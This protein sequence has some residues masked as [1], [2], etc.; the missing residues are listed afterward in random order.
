MGVVEEEEEEEEEVVEVVEEIEEEEV[1]E[2]EEEDNDDNDDNS[3]EEEEMDDSNDYVKEKDMEY[4]EEEDEEEDIQTD[5]RKAKYTYTFNGHTVPV[6]GDKDNIISLKH[7]ISRKLNVL[8]KQCHYEGSVDAS[9]RNVVH[10]VAQLAT[11]LDSTFRDYAEMC[12]LAPSFF[13]CHRKRA[14][15]RLI[16]LDRIVDEYQWEG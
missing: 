3:E 8:L 14:T 6:S 13:K 2:E 15:Q 16:D 11:E 5:A 7:I 1:E 12:R 10:L 9:M 4:D